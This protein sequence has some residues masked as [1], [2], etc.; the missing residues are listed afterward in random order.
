MKSLSNWLGEY[1][2]T[3]QNPINQQLHK[4]CVPLIVWSLIGLLNHLQILFD[5]DFNGTVIRVTWAHILCLAGLGFYTALSL[6]V[7]FFM[8]LFI[9]C[10]FFS[11]AILKDLQLD[12]PILYLFV[13]VVAWIGQFIG[14]KIE[15]AKPAFLTDIVFLFIGPLWVFR[16]VLADDFER[17][18]K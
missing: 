6:R 18:V 2:T 14:H 8:I 9:L 7:A 11:Q 13:F 12:R 1:G 5:F 15:G 16:K 10:I 17:N 4:I 3:H